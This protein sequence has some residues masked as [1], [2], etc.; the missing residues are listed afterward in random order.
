MSPETP[1]NVEA[2]RTLIELEKQRG[3][4]AG[5]ESRIEQLREIEGEGAY[6][7]YFSALLLEA[8]YLKAV[9]EAESGT[10]TPN[11]NLLEAALAHLSQ[12]D[13]L[14]PDWADVALV[15]ANTYHNMGNLARAIEYYD[16][17]VKLG[18]RRPEVI[19][20]QAELLVAEKR[21]SEADWRIEAVLAANP[22]DPLTLT[23]VP[24]LYRRMNRR[25]EAVRFLQRIVDGKGGHPSRRQGRATATI[26]PPPGKRRLQELPQGPRVDRRQFEFGRRFP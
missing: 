11:R 26:E 5:M 21:L 2:L 25:A 17:A 16:R 19:L 1:R 14:K 6:W 9:A 12:A 18:D 3:D 8:R 4:L 10:E 15:T 13:A 7:H 22:D 24:E 23:H 20:R